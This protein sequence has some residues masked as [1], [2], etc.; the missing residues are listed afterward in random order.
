MLTA[1]FNLFIIAMREDLGCGHAKM[2]LMLANEAAMQSKL[3]Y[4]KFKPVRLSVTSVYAS[5][6][7]PDS[8]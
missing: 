6:S 1:S 7:V 3:Y 8:R 4:R 2:T 5:I